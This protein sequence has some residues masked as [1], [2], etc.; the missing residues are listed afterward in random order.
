MAEDTIQYFDLAA[1]LRIEKL[2]IRKAAA[3]NLALHT[4]EYFNYLSQFLANSIQIQESLTNISSQSVSDSDINCIKITKD[5]LNKIGCD[6]YGILADSIINAIN[7][8]NKNTA[9]EYAKKL[10]AEYD[11]LQPL[12]SSAQIDSKPETMHEVINAD[13]MS[14]YN[15]LETQLLYKT[16]KLLEHEGASGKY[17]ILAVD[18]APVMLKTISATLDDNNYKVYGMQDPK[19]LKKFLF[20]IKPDLFLLDYKMPDLSGF[21]LVPIIRDFPDHKDTPIIF[22]TSMG[23]AKTVSNALALGAADYIVKPFQGKQLREK[24]AKHLKISVD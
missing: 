12:I 19:L 1:L 11:E 24:I 2:G 18:D 16:I 4:S 3:N 23:D 7:N 17:K 6:Q 20:Q 22:L 15:N 14:F 5:L 21:D 9:A 10:F 8:N 13:D